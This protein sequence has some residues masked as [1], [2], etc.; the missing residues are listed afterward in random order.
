MGISDCT[1]DEPDVLYSGVDPTEMVISPAL[2]SR[3]KSAG[4]VE[5]SQM[6]GVRRSPHLSD[7]VLIILISMRHDG[8]RTYLVSVPE[9][10]RE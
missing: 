10:K 6:S 9:P 2:F 1:E 4:E 3:R 5:T 8:F 7:D